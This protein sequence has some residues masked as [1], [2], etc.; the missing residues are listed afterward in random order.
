MLQKHFLQIFDISL[1]NR[2][3]QGC[4]YFCCQSSKFKSAEQSSYL[5]AYHILIVALHNKIWPT[6]TVLCFIQI[7]LIWALKASFFILKRRARAHSKVV[8]NVQRCLVIPRLLFWLPLFPEQSSSSS[9]SAFSQ[10]GSFFDDDYQATSL[11]V[12]ILLFA[13]PNSYLCT[14]YVCLIECY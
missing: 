1:A 11:L 12:S 7:G 10:F 5:E 4:L 9:L 8:V 2:I 14:D 6:Y 13:F 3:S